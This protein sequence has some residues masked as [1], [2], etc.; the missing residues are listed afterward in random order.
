MLKPL[1][2]E[3]PNYVPILSYIICISVLYRQ[4]VAFALRF[5]PKSP[6][7]PNSPYQ[8]SPPPPPPSTNKVE[9]NTIIIQ[10]INLLISIIHSLEAQK[11]HIFFTFRLT[12]PGIVETQSSPWANFPCCLSGIVFQPLA[13]ATRRSE[14]KNITVAQSGYSL[15]I[16]TDW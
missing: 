3:V 7:P 10:Y 5:D 9:S 12:P 8:E 15:E 2:S 1:V 11:G 4:C 13:K 14:D 6:P 16:I